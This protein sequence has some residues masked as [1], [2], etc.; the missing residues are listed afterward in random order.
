MNGKSH[1]N[2][3]LKITAF[4]RIHMT[5]I[6]MNSDGYRINGGIGFSITEP[7]IFLL[8]KTSDSFLFKDIRKANFISSEINRLKNKI[9]NI[10]LEYDFKYSIMCQICG[11]CPTHFG[12]GS[13][14]LTYLACIEALFILN[15]YPY[16]NELLTRISSRGALQVLVLIPISQGGLYLILVFHKKVILRLL[17]HRFQLSVKIYLLY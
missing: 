17:L 6:G 15:N 8:F 14:T 10:Q 7:K 3:N 12:F 2:Y 4:P 11:E 9:D 1:L 16:D 5:L 13:S